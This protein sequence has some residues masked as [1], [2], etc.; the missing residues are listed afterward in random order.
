MDKRTCFIRSVFRSV[1][2][3]NDNKDKL[4]IFYVNYF[5]QCEA[6]Q[7]EFL[8]TS[9]QNKDN[10][11]DVENNEEHDSSSEGEDDDRINFARCIPDYA[12][13]T[14]SGISEAEKRSSYSV[15]TRNEHEKVTANLIE[16]E[17]LWSKL[18][19]KRE[20]NIKNNGSSIDVYD[21]LWVINV[22]KVCNI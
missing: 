11:T 20:L 7:R 14:K 4:K 15:A 2:D 17:V 8:I 5:V 21:N 16:C 10:V 3:W 19:N 22:K 6:C 9:E 1:N 12:P 13:A 18:Y